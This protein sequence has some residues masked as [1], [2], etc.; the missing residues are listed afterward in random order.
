LISW[1]FVPDKC[2]KCNKGKLKTNLQY[3]IFSKTE[4]SCFPKLAGMEVKVILGKWREKKL[5]VRRV[6]ACAYKL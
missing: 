1:V 6:R 3:D 2:G 5:Y 4:Y